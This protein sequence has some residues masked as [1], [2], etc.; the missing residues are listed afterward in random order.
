MVVLGGVVVAWPRLR[1]APSGCS[2]RQRSTAAI[3]L[4]SV[5]IVAHL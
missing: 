1:S 2:V 3:F 5:G 4:F